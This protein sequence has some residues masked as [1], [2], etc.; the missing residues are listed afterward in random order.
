MYS[1]IYRVQS[2][3]R[4]L[5]I[6]A[7][8][9]FT[10]KQS[11]PILPSLSEYPSVVVCPRFALGR[12]MNLPMTMW[13]ALLPWTMNCIT[14]TLCHSIRWGPSLTSL[15]WRSRDALAPHPVTLLGRL[16][17]RS[18]TPVAPQV[19]RMILMGISRSGNE[20]R[21]WISQGDTH[22]SF[23][24]NLLLLISLFIIV[25]NCDVQMCSVQKVVAHLPI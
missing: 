7:L 15:K 12:L 14:S 11:S 19:R 18:I 16:V 21:V 10:L 25:S 20:D 23:F 5:P 22:A 2:S 1:S 17:P 13:M 8:F 6:R 3:T 9:G 4:R 24:T